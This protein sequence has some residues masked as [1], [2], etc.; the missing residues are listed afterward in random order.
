MEKT[1]IFETLVDLSIVYRARGL[2][3]TPDGIEILRI[4][5]QRLWLHEP[6]QAMPCHAQLIRIHRFD[7]E[8]QLYF[9][10]GLKIVA[11]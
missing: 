9:G 10:V 1:L 8:N 4:F 5:G 2:S 6:S 11:H 7:D 3:I